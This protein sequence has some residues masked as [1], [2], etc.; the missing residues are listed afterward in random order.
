MKKYFNSSQLQNRREKI[1]KN[2]LKKNYH[3]YL[4]I[5]FVLHEKKIEIF[6][7]CLIKFNSFRHCNYNSH[8]HNYCHILMFIYSRFILSKG[9]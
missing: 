2:S 8:F 9:K 1:D 6:L 3:G 7:L 5:N 4:I